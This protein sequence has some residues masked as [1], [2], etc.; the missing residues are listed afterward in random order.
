MGAFVSVGVGVGEC[1]SEDSFVRFG[2]KPTQRAWREEDEEGKVPGQSTEE[3]S[4][5]KSVEGDGQRK[6]A[7][8]RGVGTYGLRSQ[9]SQ[10]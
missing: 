1:K 10:R 5:Q 4:R 9:V 6:A 2:T 7:G 8:K 3:S